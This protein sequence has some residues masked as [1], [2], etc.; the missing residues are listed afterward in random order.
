[1]TLHGKRGCLKICHVFVDFFAFKQKIYCSFLEIKRSGVIWVV[2]FYGRHKFMTPK[3]FK[4]AT[5]LLLQALVSSST[6]NQTY[7]LTAI[8]NNPQL[9]SLHSIDDE[10]KGPITFSWHLIFNVKKNCGLMN[11][12][13]WLAS[14]KTLWTR[15]SNS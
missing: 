10:T 9:P 1:M 2:N 15:K 7:I 6:S 4:I 11:I 5:N 8:E 14:N 3:L 13:S 12:A